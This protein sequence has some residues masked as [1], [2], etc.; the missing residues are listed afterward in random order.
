MFT[1]NFKKSIL[2]GKTHVLQ[3]DEIHAVSS[4]ALSGISAER[5]DRAKVNVTHQMEG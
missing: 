2:E 4:L 5:V 3:F 1:F